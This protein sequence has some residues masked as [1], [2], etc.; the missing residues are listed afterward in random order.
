[1]EKIYIM[2]I[3]LAL[4]IF[5][6]ILAFRLRKRIGL[7]M[8]RMIYGKFSYEY[9]S[10][11]KR[12][13][14]R[15]PFQYC[16]RDEFISHVLFVLDLREEIPRYRTAAPVN[17][18]DIPF[19]SS[20]NDFLNERGEPYCFNAFSFDDPHFI[21]KVLGY[22][23]NI[24]GKKGIAAFYFINDLFFMG[25]YI[26]KDISEDIKKKCLRQFVDTDTLSG[27]NFYIEN[28]HERIIHYQD[29]GFSID[30]KYLSREDKE[31]IAVLKEYHDKMTSKTFQMEP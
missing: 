6:L 31:V 26:F 23:E 24:S 29:T 20:Y 25:E 7:M 2:A 3:S 16:F 5:L 12:I 9:L 8:V 28:T 30:I 27:D 17:F 15:S 21:V 1:M 13:V 4:G 14:N 18:E 19:Y 11:F 10:F 22:K